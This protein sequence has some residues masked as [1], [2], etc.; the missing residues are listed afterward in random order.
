MAELTEGAD[1]RSENISSL[2]ENFRSR[3]QNNVVNSLLNDKEYAYVAGYA[4]LRYFAKQASN[5][6]EAMTVFGAVQDTTH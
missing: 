5:V 1:Y 2:L 6:P 4:L 3:T